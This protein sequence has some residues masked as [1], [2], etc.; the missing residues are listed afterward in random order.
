[1]DQEISHRSF[2]DREFIVQRTM[3]TKTPKSRYAISRFDRRPL[4]QEV[5][6]TVR[7]DGHVAARLT[8]SAIRGRDFPTESEPSDQH[9]I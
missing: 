5:I 2:G 6:W 9:A 1:M 8:P 4:I 7:L 3:T